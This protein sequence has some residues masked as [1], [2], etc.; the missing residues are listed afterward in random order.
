MSTKISV[1]DKN[2]PRSLNAPVWKKYL[3]RNLTYEERF[4]IEDAKS[5]KFLNHEL[6]K[7]HLMAL[8]KDLHVSKLTNLHGN[9]L[10][11]SLNHH[12]IGGSVDEMRESIAYLLYAFGNYKDFFETQSETIREL[13]SFES[14][15]EY[16]FCT[17]DNSFYKY[18]FEVMCQDFAN[19]NSWTKL[20][21]QTI[22]MVLSVVFNLEIII[23][24]NSGYMHSINANKPETITRK[25]HLGLIGESHY[26]PLNYVTS[27]E[28]K[29]IPLYNDGRVRFFRWAT[30]MWEIVNGI[31]SEEPSIHTFDT[32]IITNQPAIDIDTFTVVTIPQDITGEVTFT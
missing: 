4:I 23:V 17:T 7:L 9:C 32:S 24:H 13:F 15:I 21:T 8:Q 12:N 11:E 29:N 20:P 27:E 6:E 1:K 16:V 3:G 25:I 5:E 31:Y 30:K 22:L 14:D 28:Q 19:N 2:F 10:F 26:V 18:T